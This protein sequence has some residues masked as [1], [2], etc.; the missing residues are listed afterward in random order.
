MGW[1]RNWGAVRKAATAV[2]LVTG[3]KIFTIPGA[4]AGGLGF[5]NLMANVFKPALSVPPKMIGSAA[6]IVAVAYLIF[7]LVRRIVQLEDTRAPDI[8]LAFDLSNQCYDTRYEDALFIHAFADSV[9]EEGIRDAE[10]WIESVDE[11]ND[12]NETIRSIAIARMNLS[13]SRFPG[14]AANKFGAMPILRTRELFDI[15]I[16]YRHTNF[17]ELEV[18]R[19]HPLSIR[20][21]PLSKRYRLTIGSSAQSMPLKLLVAFDEAGR[22]LTVRTEGDLAE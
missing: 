16:W 17:F 4:V 3:F 6:G 11:I 13:W 5:W 22:R 10:V 20:R 1:N 14:T 12:Q 8:T 18:D 7:M 21:Y 2:R 15:L 9:S 19:A